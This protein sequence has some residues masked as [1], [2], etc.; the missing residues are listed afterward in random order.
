MNGGLRH[1]V[2][3]SLL[4]QSLLLLGLQPALQPLAAAP[5][6]AAAPQPQPDG[7]SLQKLREGMPGPELR[8]EYLLRAHELL[9]QF[10]QLEAQRQGKTL[11]RPELLFNG[12]R[13]SGCGVAEVQHPM[14]FYCPTSN[15]I[16]MG[17]DLRRGTRAARGKTSAELLPMELAILAHEWGHHVNRSLGQG[18]YQRAFTFTVQQEELAA[19][20]RTGILLGWLLGQGWLSLD[21]FTAA[22]NL[23]FEI[24]DYERI[25]PQHHGYPKDRF[26]ALTEGA[27][28][29]LKP[30]QRLGEWTVDTR[31]SFCR[32]LPGTGND[33]P[34]VYEVRRFE[35]ERNGQVTTNLLG[36]ALGAASCIWGNR[37]Q[38]LGMAL[39]QGKG[40]AYGRYTSRQL[41]LDC[42]TGRFDVSD[43]AFDAQPIGRDGKGQAAVLA[44]RVCQPLAGG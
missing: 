22:S 6:P 36:A 37:D 10:W 2:L 17:L 40:R 27:A 23:M 41:R 4:L 16:A 21:D 18:P 9:H 24:G 35:I 15:Q 13:A 44:Q 38:C 14:A 1:G 29:Q 28:T 12:E 11:S 39:Q 32:P 30:G 31:E 8:R 25:T 42:A 19:D 26:L 34:L 33:G 3:R 5:A 43:D 7:S 20:W